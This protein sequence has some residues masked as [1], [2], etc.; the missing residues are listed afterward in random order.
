MGTT[1]DPD[2]ILSH[3]REWNRAAGITIHAIGLS[4]A[5][6]AYLLENLAHQN[7]GK[8]VAR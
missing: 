3:V 4:G 1:V 2:E 7:G 5:Q 6:D 8:Y